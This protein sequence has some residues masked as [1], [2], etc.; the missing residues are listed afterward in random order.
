MSADLNAAGA[1]M[2]PTE[3]AWCAEAT[4]ILRQDGP[5]RGTIESRCGCPDFEENCDGH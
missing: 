3:R 4:H 5:E 1:L 2:T